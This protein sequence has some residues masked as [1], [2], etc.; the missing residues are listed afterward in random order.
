M[1]PS[2]SKNNNNRDLWRYAGLTT[3]IFAGLGIGVLAGIKCDEWLRI[4]VPVF[5]WLI[6]LIIIIVIIYKLIKDTAN[7]NERK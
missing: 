6:P 1:S 4:S 3:Q 5:V 7:K 2:P